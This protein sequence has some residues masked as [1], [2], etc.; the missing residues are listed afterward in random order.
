MNNKKIKGGLPTIL[1][2]GHLT[3]LQGQSQK[4]LDKHNPLEYILDK[5]DKYVP[6]SYGGSIIPPKK[7]NERVLLLQST[8]GSGKS[9]AFIAGLY[10]KY[11]ERTQKIIVSCQPTTSVAQNNAIDEGTAPHNSEFYELGENIGWQTGIS[12][13]KV[14]RG[15]IYMTYGILEQQFKVM[16]DE[17]IMDRYSFIVIDE[18]HT[19][20]TGEDFVIY[21]IRELIKKHYKSPNCPFLILT[22]AT[23]NLEEYA[24]YFDLKIKDAIRVEGLNYPIKNHFLEFDS[25]DFVKDAAK[26]AVEIYDGVISGKI[27]ADKSNSDSSNSSSNKVEQNDILIFCPTNGVVLKICKLLDVM[28]KSKGGNVLKY[29]SEKSNIKLNTCN[30]NKLNYIKVK[31]GGALKKEDNKKYVDGIR[32]YISG[33]NEVSFKKRDYEIIILTSATYKGNGPDMRKLFD[34]NFKKI[35]IIVATNT[36]ETGITFANL[37][38]VID[39]GLRFTNEFTPIFS[40]SMLLTMPIVKASALQ[41][42]GRVGRKFPGNWYPLYTE[43]AFNNMQI[44]QFPDIIIEDPAPVILSL[45]ASNTMSMKT[46]SK[47][48]NTYKNI[49][50]IDLL[51]NPAPDSVHYGI[52]K[53]FCLG[54][55]DKDYQ[56]TEVGKMV[57]LFRMTTIENARMIMAGYVYKANIFDLIVISSFIENMKNLRN[58]RMGINKGLIL[59]K[60]DIKGYTGGDDKNYKNKKLTKE[61]RELYNNIEYAKLFIA[62]EFIYLLYFYD[63]VSKLYYKSEK[64][65]IDFCMKN[66][67]SYGEIKS[68][69]STIISKLTTVRTGLNI[70]LSD[71]PRFIKEQ[72][73]DNIKRIKQCIYEGY[74]LNLGIWNG[75]IYKFRSGIELNPYHIKDMTPMRPRFNEGN[76]SS[77]PKYIITDRIILRKGMNNKNIYEFE[78]GFI[79]VIDGWVD[80]EEYG[81]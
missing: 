34:D 50:N 75:S 35:R 33:G 71:T 21:M 20:T 54:L 16:T 1:Q 74:K 79:S 65:L 11:Q 17:E 6:T 76:I 44:E 56:I 78:P 27:V 66:K 18:V 81:P 30:E 40:S 32:N 62:D 5:F 80:L 46:V 29:N 68:V 51:T 13:K 42:K 63:I 38:H 10:K 36:A 47:G 31:N 12:K 48:N 58:I 77:R 8:T 9:T 49:I 19:R 3:A 22:S 23:F 52:H 14:R 60:L 57:N 61:E 67:F 59:P 4:E 45:I 37:G 28:R 15:V 72:S 25:Q 64:K 55:I 41:R 26:K 73:Q 39:I 2:K 70:P 24:P 69:M 43:E 7:W 53:L